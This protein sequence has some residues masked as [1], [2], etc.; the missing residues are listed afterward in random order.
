MQRIFDGVVFDADG[1]TQKSIRAAWK[2]TCAVFRHHKVKPPTFA[3]YREHFCQP[4]DRFYN[5]RGVHASLATIYDLFLPA[6]ERY[7]TEMYA[8]VKPTFRLLEQH[9][10]PYGVVSAQEERLLLGYFSR[11][12]VGLEFIRGGVNDKAKA[13]AEFCEHFNLPPMRVAS[14]G[15][16]VSDMLF[17][18]T[19][20]LRPIGIARGCPH[21]RQRLIGAGA[22]ECVDNLVEFLDIMFPEREM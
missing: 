9:E 17:S 12:G 11:E 14:V 10:I 13:M 22:E 15:D 18:K 21:A 7:E 20:G 2:A 8:D 5:E 6:F 4:F 3:E 1:T 19:A 16:F